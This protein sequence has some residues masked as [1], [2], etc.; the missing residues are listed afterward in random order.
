[1][2]PAAAGTGPVRFARYA[3]PPNALGLCGPDDPAGLLEAAATGDDP[4]LLG[5]RAARF[6]AAWPYLQLIAA[7]NRIDDP[8]DPRVVDAYWVGNGLLAAV[9][10]PALRRLVT[11]RLSPGLPPPPVLAAAASGWCQHSFHVLCVS[12]WLGLLRAGRVGPALDVLDRCRIRTGTV[13]AVAGDAV[14]VVSRPLEWSGSRLVVGAARS[15]TVRRAVDGVGLAGELAP[16]DTVALHWDWVCERLGP[17]ARRRLETA[18]TRNLAVANAGPRP[19]AAAA[20]G[21]AR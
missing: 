18:T 14:V 20:E 8:L 11:E 4:A 3:Y 16:G 15:E 9:S 10:G 17:S 2:T 7:A 5:D 21:W 13:T 19:V 6:E 1:M 12:P